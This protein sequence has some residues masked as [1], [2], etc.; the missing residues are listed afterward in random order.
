[1]PRRKKQSSEAAVRDVLRREKIRIVLDGL[2]SE[3]RV[4]ELCRRARQVDATF[5]LRYLS[6][7]E[8]SD[9]RLLRPHLHGAARLFA[10]ARAAQ[11]LLS[12]GTRSRIASA[13][14][15]LPAAFGW[16]SSG[17][18]YSSACSGVFM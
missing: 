16:P 4:A 2:R 9:V 11:R 1:M 17:K 8:Q 7:L 10:D 15:K 18:K 12:W 6:A 14:A 5:V 13:I 3:I